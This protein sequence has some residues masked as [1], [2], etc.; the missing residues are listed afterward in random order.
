MRAHGQIIAHNSIQYQRSSCTR[1][2]FSNGFFQKWQKKNTFWAK[3]WF[4]GS[5]GFK[6]LYLWKKSHLW[7]FFRHPWRI[8]SECSGQIFFSVTFPFL[9][10]KFGKTTL[11]K[12]YAFC[13][14]TK[15]VLVTPYLRVGSL[16]RKENDNNNKYPNQSSFL[17]QGVH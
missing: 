1:G 9:Q 12:K 5:F 11:G 2:N 3:I 17:I 6:K 13:A 15:R 14:S 4:L 8:G 10:N 7:S 16:S